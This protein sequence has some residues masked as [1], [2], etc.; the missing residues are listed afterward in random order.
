MSPQAPTK[1]IKV[2]D[3]ISWFVREFTYMLPKADLPVYLATA[4]WSREIRRELHQFYL[5]DSERQFKYSAAY[6][7]K[8]Y[9]SDLDSVT[10]EK[11][12]RGALHPTYERLNKKTSMQEANYYLRI[13]TKINTYP[14]DT[15]CELVQMLDPRVLNADF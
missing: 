13:V 6:L 3:K 14:F 12:H 15:P 2:F 9:L 11:D 5:T 4:R 10:H 8:H 7:E 1:L